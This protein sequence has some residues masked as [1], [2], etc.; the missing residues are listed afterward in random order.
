MMYNDEEMLNFVY[1]NTEMG[2]EGISHLV[3]RLEPEAHGFN[4]ALHAQQ[5]EYHSLLHACEDMLDERNVQIQPVSA[6]AKASSHVMASAKTMV[7]RSPEK[8]AEMMAQGNAMGIIKAT[9]HL[10]AYDGQDERVRDIANKL[11]ETEKANFNEM[12]KFL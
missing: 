11:L 3:E 1:Q 8:M 2:L 9:Q 7:D 10:K 4:G 6:M 12:L 5:K